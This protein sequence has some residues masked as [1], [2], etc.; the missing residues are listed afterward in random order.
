MNTI[1]FQTVNANKFHDDKH[2]DRRFPD[3]WMYVGRGVQRKGLKRSP[4]ANPY[5]SRPN[6][7]A[8][9]VDSKKEAVAKFKIWLWKRMKAGDESVLAELRKVTDETTLVCHCNDTTCHSFVVRKAA[10]WLKEQEA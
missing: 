9:I 2:L 10:K 7:R 3:G 4:L 1:K 5:S 8:I 6:A